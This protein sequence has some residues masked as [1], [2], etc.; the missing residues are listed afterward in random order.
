[1]NNDP[2]ERP[3]I[4]LMP[5]ST[6]DMKR[7]LDILDAMERFAKAQKP[8]PVEWVVELKELVPW[9]RTP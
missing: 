1:M 8:I 2:I 4:G 9:K 3:P 6:H 7:A 5:K